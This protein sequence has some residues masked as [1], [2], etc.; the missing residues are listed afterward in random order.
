MPPLQRL[1]TRPYL[2]LTLTSL[3]WAGN[4]VVGRAVA[5]RIPPIALSQVR[6]VLALL[7][8][9]PFAWRSLRQDARSIRA[10]VWRLA[11]LALT[12]IA[13]FN[14][15]LYW[16]L[17]R[18]TAINATLMQSLGPLMIGLWSLLL[19]GESLTRR[20]LAGI[21]VSLV[22]V[23]VVVSDG[24]VARLARLN[25]NI[26]DVVVIV[27]MAIY[28]LYSALLRTR[29]EIAPLSFLAVTVALGAAMLAPLTI[30][31]HFSSGTASIRLAPA[32]FAAI[33]Y[34]AIFPSLIAYLCFNRGV[35]LIG[36]NRSGPFLHLI[37]LFGALLAIVF[38][39]ERPGA[40]HGVGAAL[41][42]GG[43]FIASRG[44]SADGGNRVAS[45]GPQP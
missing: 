35:Q 43:V 34:V 10:H 40:H 3:F 6:W 39:G 19:F 9:L 29:P 12:G 5:D 26:G 33:A 30:V 14:T 23:A 1:W 20:Q 32:T 36:A 13:A 27:A 16:S 17:H 38:L 24:D 11:F 21:L 41:I 45:G 4:A 37:P 8:L 22:G 31:E 28:A 18:T 25:L 15:M 2:L 7:I 44:G 42:L